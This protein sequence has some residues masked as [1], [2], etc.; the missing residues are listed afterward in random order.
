MLLIVMLCLAHKIPDRLLRLEGQQCNGFTV[1]VVAALTFIITKAAGIAPADLTGLSEQAL[2][3]I[4]C[5]AHAKRPDLV[6]HLP[7][8]P[9]TR[10]E[11]HA[12]R[13]GL[14][15][16]TD[17]LP[18]GKDIFDITDRTHPAHGGLM[19][20]TLQIIAYTKRPM[21]DLVSR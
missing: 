17:T 16:K 7:D 8:I 11:F 2:W 1:G 14:E 12:I 15:K 3:R 19:S 6:H 21:N 20:R 10:G 4:A 5:K 18:M 9:L 13:W